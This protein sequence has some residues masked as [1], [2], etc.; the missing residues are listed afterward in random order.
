MENCSIFVHSKY[1]LTMY[2]HINCAGEVWNNYPIDTLKDIQSVVGGRFK[3]IQT[4]D[5]FVFVK[6][7]V[8]GEVLPYNYVA[9]QKVSQDIF[10]TVLLTPKEK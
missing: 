4:D 2:L 3:L 6:D 9:S 10:G 5:M 1:K 8:E 7:R